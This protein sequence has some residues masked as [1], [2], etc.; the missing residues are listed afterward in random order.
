MG[1]FTGKTVIITGAG[2]AKSIGYGVATAYAKE[3]ADLVITG[4]N[5]KKLEGARELEQYGIR[6]L[7][8]QADGGNEDEVKMVVKAAVETFGHIDVLINCAQASR[9]GVLLK[10]HTKEDFD[11]AVYSGLYATFFFMREC[12]PYLKESR[13]SVINFASGAGLFGRVAQSSY[14]A[15]K[16]GIRGLSRVAATEWGP[17]GI[18]I[19]CVCPLAMTAELEHW[20]DNYPEAY[21]AT[22]KGVPLGRYGNPEQDIGRVCVF[23]GSRDAK[24]ISGETFTIQGGSGLR[25]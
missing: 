18:N 21:N 7:P 10:D 5:P 11:L 8:I 12:Y 22:I 3:G 15:A 16:E 20:R 17:D 6:V 23:L 4:R 25:P 14:A 24:Y 1:I 19:N 2:K 13:G 9:S